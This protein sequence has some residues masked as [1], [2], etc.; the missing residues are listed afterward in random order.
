MRDPLEQ[1]ILD[2]K[3]E[4]DVYEP[5]DRLWERIDKELYA[6][7]T[8]A[9]FPIW[10]IAAAILLLFSIGISL[11]WLLNSQP[12]MEQLAANPQD[13]YSPELVE[14]EAYYTSMIDNQKEQLQ[15]YAAEGISVDESSF[16]QLEELGNNYKDLQKELLN[17]E[18]SQI[19]VNAMIQN[20]SM[21]MEILNQQI[22]ILEQIK[23]MKNENQTSL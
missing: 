19:V 23:S 16:G 13:L 11:V 22:M 2:R 4:L 12:E 6:E 20:L 3:Q 15:A 1:Y 7:S 21:Q 5:D 10:K 8:K 18:D 9:K 17:T 14:V